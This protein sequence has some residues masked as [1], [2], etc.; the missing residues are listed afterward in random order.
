LVYWFSLPTE[1]PFQMR[2]S[3][4]AEPTDSLQAAISIT[5]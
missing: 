3:P 2:F 4:L 1:G 5:A